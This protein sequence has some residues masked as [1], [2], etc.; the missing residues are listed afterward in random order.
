MIEVETTMRLYHTE[1]TQECIK[2]YINSLCKCMPFTTDGITL[3][4][5]N[6]ILYLPDYTAIVIHGVAPN[7]LIIEDTN[8]FSITIDK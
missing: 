7:S 6:D 5:I 3:D 8:A 1:M 2:Q 4:R